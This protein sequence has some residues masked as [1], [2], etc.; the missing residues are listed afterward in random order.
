MNV[1][2]YLYYVIYRITMDSNIFALL[3]KN[4]QDNFVFL[5]AEDSVTKSSFESQI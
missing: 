3:Y 1:D 2:A 5:S 4:R